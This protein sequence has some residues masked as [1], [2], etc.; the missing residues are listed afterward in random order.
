M[1]KK[2]KHKQK[3]Q[4]TLAHYIVVQEKYLKPLRGE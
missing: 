4:L 1:K 3:K 2:Y